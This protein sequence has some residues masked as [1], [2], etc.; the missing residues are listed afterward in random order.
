MRTDPKFK[1]V[2]YKTD[3][4]LLKSDTNEY[5]YNIQTIISDAPAGIILKKDAKKNLQDF[6]NI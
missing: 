4:D 2:L 3:P 1:T 5:N 6:I